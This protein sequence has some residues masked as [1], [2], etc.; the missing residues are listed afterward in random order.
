M[1]VAIDAGIRCPLG[2]PKVSRT[3]CASLICQSHARSYRCWDPLTTR[4]GHLR[5]SKWTA[6]TSPHLGHGCKRS[7]LSC[8]ANNPPHVRCFKLGFVNLDLHPLSAQFLSVFSASAA[9]DPRSGSFPWIPCG[10]GVIHRRVHGQHS[11]STTRRH[12][13]DA[14][15]P[16]TRPNFGH[17]QA[18]APKRRAGID[19][20]LRWCGYCVHPIASMMTSPSPPTR[21][22]SEGIIHIEKLTSCTVSL[23]DDGIN[24]SDVAYR[25]FPHRLYHLISTHPTSDEKQNAR[26]RTCSHLTVHKSH[27]HQP[28]TSHEGDVAPYLFPILDLFSPR[29]TDRTCPTGSILTPV[30]NDASLISVSW[31]GLVMND[32]PCTYRHSES[33]QRRDHRIRA[34]SGVTIQGVDA[35]LVRDL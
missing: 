33:M 22:T 35:W 14:S 26:E 31:Q 4:T 30:T 9:W 25:T 18:L 23:Q 28:T 5:Q 24:K 32:L 29:R 34:T 16:K 12:D 8:S 21:W 1:R 13:W 11:N 19:D 27:R 7:G 15:R 2:L 10:N 3:D 6:Q 20:A 17:G